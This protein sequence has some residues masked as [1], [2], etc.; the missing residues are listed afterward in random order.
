MDCEES[1][2]I[3]LECAGSVPDGFCDMEQCDML[4]KPIKYPWEGCSEFLPRTKKINN[5][6]RHDPKGE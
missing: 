6:R 3:C 2:C 5:T 1:G 4:C